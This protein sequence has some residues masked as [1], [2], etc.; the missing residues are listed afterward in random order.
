MEYW[1]VGGVITH[2]SILLKNRRNASTGLSMNG[3]SPVI[4]TALPFVPSINSGQALRLSKDER[5][6]FQQNHDSGTP[7][8]QSFL[9]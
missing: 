4:S 1:N 8:F 3:K 2:D 5:K 7:L 6:V 9:W